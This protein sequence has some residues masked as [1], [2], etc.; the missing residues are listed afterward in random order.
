MIITKES[1]NVIYTQLCVFELNPCNLNVHFT[2]QNHVNSLL[3][4][5]AIFLSRS[6]CTVINKT[7]VS[8]SLVTSEI[9][10]DIAL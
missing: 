9:S 7:L 5:V 6:V 3:Q 4:N 10:M 1:T 2:I 8:I